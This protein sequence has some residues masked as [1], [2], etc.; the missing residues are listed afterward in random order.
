MRQFATMLLP[1]LAILIA[2]A[3]F[4]PSGSE[5]SPPPVQVVEDIGPSTADPG[6]RQS[7]ADTSR[8][9]PRPS[10]APESEKTRR[11][12][13][14]EEDP[15]TVN[16][17]ALIFSLSFAAE[18]TATHFPVLEVTEAAR[19]LTRHPEAADVF[20]AA[21]S[22]APRSDA[23]RRL[24][25]TLLHT[26]YRV[27]D[28]LLRE[29]LL[30][31]HRESDPTAAR[32]KEILGDRE[33]ILATLLSHSDADLLSDVIGRMGTPLLADPDI[34][35]AMLGLVRD[36]E[37]P[38]IRN[39]ALGRIGR[40][41][42][43]QVRELLIS[44]LADPQRDTSERQTAARVLMRRPGPDTT[45]VFLEIINLNE[46]APLLRFSA[47][48]LKTDGGEPEVADTLLRLLLTESADGAARKNA[49][50]A[51]IH[52]VR[53]ATG[54][55]ALP[56]EE[57]LRAALTDLSR[58]ETSSAVLVHAMG[59]MTQG[60]AGRFDDDLAGI[61]RM[62]SGKELRVLLVADRTLMKFLEVQ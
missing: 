4:G 35:E 2:A 58:Q 59:E 41:D 10:S 17:R 53:I 45:P 13:T 54:D 1:P 24:R 60:L 34:R 29:H 62:H 25:A 51:L 50:T 39:R 26:F 15:V 31:A 48:G 55:E 43:P 47:L 61:L 5:A 56:L 32:I 37:D 38:K 18:S 36:S 3:I 8:L 33:M 30:K 16:A 28:S 57:R 46:S 11:A 23:H 40:L 14:G 20:V 42:D 21:L 12:P 6:A 52:T 22:D 19:L 9:A 27:E 49:A 44:T 7:G